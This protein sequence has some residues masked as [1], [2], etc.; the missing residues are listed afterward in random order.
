MLEHLVLPA[1]R[2]LASSSAEKLIEEVSTR[3]KIGIRPFQRTKRRVLIDRL[4]YDPRV[5]EAT[6]DFARTK[7][8]WKNCRC[9]ATTRTRSPI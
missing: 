8:A 5:Q 3:L 2:F 1:L 9:C 7:R 6:R 4:V